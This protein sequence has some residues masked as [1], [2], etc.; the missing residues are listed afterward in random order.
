MTIAYPGRVAIPFQAPVSHEELTN[1]FVVKRGIEVVWQKAILCPCLT[2][3]GIPRPT[4][5]YCIGRGFTHIGEEVI[6]VLFT[7]LSGNHA[8]EDSGLWVY[9]MSF[10]STPGNIKLGIRD[11]LRIDSLHTVYLETVPIEGQ[12]LVLNFAPVKLEDVYYIDDSGRLVS[13][14]DT[15]TVSGNVVTLTEPKVSDGVFFSFRYLAPLS[16]LV[17]SAVHE[18]RGWKDIRGNVISLPNQYVVQREDM[19]TQEKEV[20]VKNG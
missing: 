6:P 16:F 15:V 2:P 12:R 7:R 9:G 3:E 14:K 19:V 10:I 1:E 17:M 11:R 5:R 13:V 20:W 8:V 4:C 18:V